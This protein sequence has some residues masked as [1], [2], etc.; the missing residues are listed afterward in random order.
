MI[1]RTGVVRTDVRGHGLPRL[2]G[3]H[4]LLTVMI[5]SAVASGALILLSPDPA[6]N[7]PPIA[8]DVSLFAPQHDDELRD[9]FNST[10]PLVVERQKE[11]ADQVRSNRQDIAALTTQVQ[12]V[13][14]EVQSV[15]SLLTYLGGI[16]AALVAGVA[17]Q[18]WQSRRVLKDGNVNG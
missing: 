2:G 7:P 15:R 16:L 4:F 12:L 10:V 18:I 17:Q 6:N 11:I 8:S 5:G 9:R 14:A 3:V 1:E 13:C